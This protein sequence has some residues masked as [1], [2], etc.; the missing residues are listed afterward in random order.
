MQSA[1]TQLTDVAARHKAGIAG[2]VA[3]AALTT[4]LIVAA[5]DSWSAEGWSAGAAWVTAAIAVVAGSVAIEQLREARRIRREQAQP[6]LAVFT[7]G[8]NLV[9]ARFIDLVIRNLGTTA[10]YDVDVE[11][12]PAPQRAGGDGRARL[13]WMPDRI[14]VLVPGQEWRTF[15][16]FAPRRATTDLP[17]RHEAVVTFNDSQRQRFELPYVLDWS[18]Y[19][20]RMFVT[21]TVCITRRRRYARLIRSSAGGRRALAAA[22]Q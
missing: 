8:N 5:V 9:D 7:D 17:D 18:S 10:A 11:I 21:T 6:Y 15:W 2:V 13:V 19:K 16:D 4:L 1:W 22:S 14:P 12:H 3:F 20:D